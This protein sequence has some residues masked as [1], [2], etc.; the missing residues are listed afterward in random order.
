MPD[1]LTFEHVRDDPI[2]GLS[3]GIA[4]WQEQAAKSIAWK[5]RRN[6]EHFQIVC[7]ENGVTLK[8]IKLLALDDIEEHVIEHVVAALV[9]M[10]SYS[11]ANKDLC[12]NGGVMRHLIVH[13][14]LHKDNQSIV[15]EACCLLGNVTASFG[16]FD[17]I[18]HLP[19][20]LLAV[21]FSLR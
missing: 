3:S 19:L 7:S 1:L 10:T 2:Q 4:R 9:T 8:L 11:N 20:K 15:S 18:G 21:R 5:K 17:L 12:V 14:R 6:M 13:L 16:E